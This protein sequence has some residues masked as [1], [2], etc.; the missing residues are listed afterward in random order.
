[1]K[2][3][4]CSICGKEMLVPDDCKFF[5]C[6]NCIATNE[7][8]YAREQL[9]KMTEERDNAR[10]ECAGYRS[11]VNLVGGQRDKANEMLSRERDAWASKQR[12]AHKEWSEVCQECVQVANERDAAIKD[13]DEARTN[14]VRVC[15][16]RNAAG[17]GR[18]KAQDLLVERTAQLDK[19]LEERNEALAQRDNAMSTERFLIDKLEHVTTQRDIAT[20]VA[21]EELVQRAT[22]M[23]PNITPPASPATGDLVYVVYTDRAPITWSYPCVFL[24]RNS[25]MHCAEKH[26][27]EFPHNRV[28]VCIARLGDTGTPYHFGLHDPHCITGPWYW[29]NGVVSDAR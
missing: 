16:E 18:A 27:K 3:L 1:M 12:A 4:N 26:S 7:A 23:C 2:C 19:A 10:R 29:T 13:R 5:N 24:G 28:G 17:S 14:Y 6:V 8:S 20:R 22:A 21:A 25:A 11:T 15:D 9:R